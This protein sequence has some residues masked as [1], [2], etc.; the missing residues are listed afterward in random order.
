VHTGR[1]VKES[2][3]RGAVAVAKLNEPAISPSGS[4]RVLDKDVVKSAFI[5][6]ADSEDS[7]VKSSSTRA[8]VG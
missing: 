7:M 5:A 2:A 1:V 8:V 3:S 4:P 6:V